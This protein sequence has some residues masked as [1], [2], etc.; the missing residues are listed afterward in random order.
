MINYDKHSRRQTT[1]QIAS[2]FTTMAGKQISEKT[3]KKELKEMV[4]NS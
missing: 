1:L 2:A 3:T 4:V